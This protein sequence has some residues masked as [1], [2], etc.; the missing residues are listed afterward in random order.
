MKKQLIAILFLFFFFT[1]SGQNLDVEYQ[2]PI[3]PGTVQWNLL[4]ST[5]DMYSACQI[6]PKLLNAL[7]TNALVKSCLHYPAQSVL[8]LGNTPQQSFDNWKSHFN[9]INE[10][11]NREEA[12]AHLFAVYE[13]FDAKGYQ[14]LG[15]SVERG[16]H[17]FKL[18]FLEW[19]L[20]QDE[21][22][23]KASKPQLQKALAKAIKNFDLIKQD[24]V[25]GFYN[26][27]ILGRVVV[28][29]SEKLGLGD[30]SLQSPDIVEFKHSGQ[31]KNKVMLVN[32]I[33]KA[34]K[35]I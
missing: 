4:K 7:S 5:L 3:I 15:N 1:T 32:L 6:P 33:D 2:Y 16:K 25:Y 34:R 9:G 14:I 12:F 17:A 24:P 18:S 28:K 10:L 31:A 26:I 23:S 8:L 11:L 20:G 13:N 22:L 21:I 19:I 27:E 35:L 29:I 30:S